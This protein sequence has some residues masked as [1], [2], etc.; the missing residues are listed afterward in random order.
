M[1]KTAL[2]KDFLREIKKTFTRFL[3]I[4]IMIM[5]GVFVLIGL[6]VTGPMMRD[7]ATRHTDAQNMY[8][9]KIIGPVGIDDE[10]LREI[11]KIDGVEIIYPG[12]LLS[13]IHI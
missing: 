1:K 8:D 11:K 2:I 9:I 7:N 4:T 10:D 3:S 12:K 6:K 5:L 13:L